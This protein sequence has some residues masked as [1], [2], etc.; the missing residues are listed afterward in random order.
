MSRKLISEEQ[1]VTIINERLKNSDHADGDC[2][3][4]Y[5]KGFYHLTE[6][7]SEGC[8]WQINGYTGPPECLKVVTSVV[9][10][11]RAIYNLA[12]SAV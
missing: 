5:I 4:C 7:D 12:D 11:L 6:P 3:E 1:L 9:R 2:R 8:N 10:S